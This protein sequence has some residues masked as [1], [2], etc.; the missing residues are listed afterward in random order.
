MFMR[1]FA[2]LILLLAFAGCDQGQQ[3]MKPVMTPTPE[4]PQSA[5][6]IP[7]IDFTIP[8]RTEPTIPEN[9]VQE[10]YDR[11]ERLSSGEDW[12]QNVLFD[13]AADAYSADGTKEMFKELEDQ[14]KCDPEMMAAIFT[15]A[16]T[17][18]QARTDFLLHLPEKYLG[19]HLAPSGQPST[20]KDVRRP[21]LDGVEAKGYVFSVY[22]IVFFADDDV[23]YCHRKFRP[24]P[25]IRLC[26][27]DNLFERSYPMA[28]RRKFTAQFK[29]EVVLEALR[30]ESSQAEL[31][32]RY[33]LS[34]TQ[35]STWKQQ[36]IEILM[37]GFATQNKQSSESAKRIAELE[38]L[39]GRLTLDAE[40]Q[41][42]ATTLLS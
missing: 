39:V 1:F 12:I 41:K 4:P 40:I 29:A 42:K 33:N 36:G 18:R 16:F 25:N 20:D 9:Y 21:N 26:Y 2:L 5:D 32:R 27:N 31:C 34:E 6:E 17:S 10:E 28:K 8:E 23:L 13:S 15:I 30:G 11:V 14:L 24:L 19:F 3:M 37:S 22:G 7:S 38:R 35:I